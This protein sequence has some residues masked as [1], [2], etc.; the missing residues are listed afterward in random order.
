M[1]LQEVAA[2]VPLEIWLEV[3]FYLHQKRLEQLPQLP[4]EVWQLIL[5]HVLDQNTCK[6]LVKAHS[7][8]RGL[9]KSCRTKRHLVHLFL[10]MYCTYENQQ[11]WKLGSKWLF[12]VEV[13][14][15]FLCVTISFHSCKCIYFATASTLQN[16]IVV[17]VK[18]GEIYAIVYSPMDM[19][20]KVKR[21]TDWTGFDDIYSFDGYEDVPYDYVN[22]KLHLKAKA[23]A[24]IMFKV[25]ELYTHNIT[26]Y[27]DQI[28]NIVRKHLDVCLLVRNKDLI[29]LFN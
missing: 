13:E 4:L 9:L 7:E 12:D 3:A 22:E 19:D 26:S 25:M 29:N 10:Q 8:L 27:W 16:Q 21:R 1:S 23:V 18:D 20:G 14:M 5:E 28:E 6:C 17:S 11:Y 15:S 2:A 24:R